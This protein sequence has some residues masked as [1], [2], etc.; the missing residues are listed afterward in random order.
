MSPESFTGAR[1]SLRPSLAV[2]IV[3]VNSQRRQRYRTALPPPPYS[4]DNHGVIIASEMVVAARDTLTKIKKIEREKYSNNS[5]D[6]LKDQP[7]RTRCRTV[8]AVVAAITTYATLLHTLPSIYS[9]ATYNRD[10]ILD[11]ISLVFGGE[12]KTR[13]GKEIILA[14]QQPKLTPILLCVLSL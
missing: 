13:G 8:L 11:I 14:V 3:C 6:V 10:P 9:V 2:F 5:A 7:C 4:K 1:I 12:M